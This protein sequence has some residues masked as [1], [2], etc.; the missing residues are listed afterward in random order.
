MRGPSHSNS[1]L[2]VTP[3]G[4]EI[5]QVR[6]TLLPTMIGDDGDEDIEILADSVE[7]DEEHNILC[8]QHKYYY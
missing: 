4:R 2:P 8:K 5:E 7:N 3:P 6:L 1:G